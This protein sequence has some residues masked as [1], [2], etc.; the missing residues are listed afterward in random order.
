M[1]STTKGFHSLR[2][3]GAV[4]SLPLPASQGFVCF[5]PTDLIPPSHLNPGPGI[6]QNALELA[7]LGQ[8]FSRP[9]E[10]IFQLYLVSHQPPG[11][12][13]ANSS[14]VSAAEGGMVLRHVLDR[15]YLKVGLYEHSGQKDKQRN[16]STPASPSHSTLPLKT[17]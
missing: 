1:L 11:C 4:T 14:Q 2:G 16:Y 5:S 15:L 7:G 9:D 12:W 17:Q 13:R 10:A 8:E 3:R 6:A